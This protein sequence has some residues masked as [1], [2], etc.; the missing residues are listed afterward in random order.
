[1]HILFV[2]RS[3]MDRDGLLMFSFKIVVLLGAIFGSSRGHFKAILGLSWGHFWV[4]MAFRRS[5]DV[6]M[7]LGRLQ[8]GFNVVSD[9]LKK[10]IMNPYKHEGKSVFECRTCR[11][12]RHFFDLLQGVWLV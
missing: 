6:S 4:M 1:M 11:E 5:V 3:M 2:G 8:D 7:M 9:C 12:M 10:A